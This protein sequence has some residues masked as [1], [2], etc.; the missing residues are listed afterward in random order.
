MGD[1]Q[2]SP[3]IMNRP[4]VTIDGLCVM[5]LIFWALTEFIVKLAESKFGTDSGIFYFVLVLCIVLT[6]AWLA[7]V[8]HAYGCWSTQMLT[9]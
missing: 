6:V 2:S 4:V 5:F 1:T 3:L 9:H 7:A 8:G